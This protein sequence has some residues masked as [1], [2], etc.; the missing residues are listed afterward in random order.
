MGQSA[1][2]D[3]TLLFHSSF[4]FLSLLSL[5]LYCLH[6]GKKSVNVN[7]KTTKNRHT[8]YTSISIIYLFN[9]LLFNLYQK[10]WDNCTS[11]TGT[12]IFFPVIK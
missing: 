2:F 9:I 11:V 1:H 4:R 8:I 12:K 10:E 6:S 5:S 7:I 3:P